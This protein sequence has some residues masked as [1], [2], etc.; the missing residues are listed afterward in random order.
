MY[1]KC[2]IFRVPNSNHDTIVKCGKYLVC[3]TSKSHYELKEFKYFMQLWFKDG[4]ISF[5]HMLIERERER[6]WELKY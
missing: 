5:C 6:E 2:Q 1:T 4:D 3:K